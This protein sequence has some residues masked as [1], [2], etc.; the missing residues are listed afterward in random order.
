MVKFLQG[1]HDSRSTFTNG[2]LGLGVM[3]RVDIVQL[4]RSRRDLSM[5]ESENTVGFSDPIASYSFLVGIVMLGGYGGSG[6]ADENSYV[7]CV[8]LRI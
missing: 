4:D 3:T 2:G 5:S 6:W 8:H 7:P 1:V